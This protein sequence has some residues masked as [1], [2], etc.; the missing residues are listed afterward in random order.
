MIL[1]YDSHILTDT[2]FFRLTMDDCSSKKNVCPV[3]GDKFVWMKSV[4]RHFA[5]KHVP[6]REI[7]RCTY[8]MKPFSTKVDMRIHLQDKHPIVKDRFLCEICGHDFAEKRYMKRH[9]KEKH[10]S[11]PNDRVNCPDCKKSFTRKGNMHE[12]WHGIHDRQ[13]TKSRAD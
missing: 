13:L 10:F 4:Y 8:C 2:S 6:R 5:S 11:S 7:Y 1:I 3:C 9:Q 12:H